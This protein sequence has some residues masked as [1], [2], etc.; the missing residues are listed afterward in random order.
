[1]HVLKHPV[2]EGF[3][4]ERVHQVD[5]PLARQLAALI[6]FR[7]VAFYLREV[8]RLGEELFHAEPLVLRHRQVLHLVA[9]QKLALTVDERLEE[10][11]CVALVRSQVGTA[12]DAEEVIPTE[13]V[14][15]GVVTYTSRLERYLDAN[16]VDVTCD[17]W[18]SVII[19]TMQ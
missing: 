12:L 7:E 13:D 1:M 14:S 17:C 15:E 9:V 16:M 10:V 6:W 2:G 11:D 3:A 5:Q 19:V 8:G 18:L 4:S